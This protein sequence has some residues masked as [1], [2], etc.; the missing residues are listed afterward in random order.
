MSDWGGTNSVV[1]SIEA[2][3]DIQMP[4]SD[5]YR[6]EKTLQAI[7][8]G[9]LSKEAVEKAAANILYLVERTKGNDLS[10]EPAER[11]D[12]REETR[13]LIRNLGAE[14]LTL[15]KNEGNV[16]PIKPS[17]TKIAVIGS[18][19]NRAIAGGGGSAS[20]NPYY[21]TLPLDSIKAVPGKEVIYALGCHTYKWLPLAADYC[22]TASGEQG[23]MLEFFGGDQFEGTPKVI[24]QRSNTDLFLWDSAPLEVVGG[25]WSVRA[26]TRITPV[27]SGRHTISF[28]TVGPGRLL[29]D[30]EVKVDLWNW[31]EQGEAMFDNS[32]DI[33]VEIQMEAGKEIELVAET[34]NE[35]RPMWKQKPGV[36]HKYGGVRI[37]YKEED[38]QDL[39]QEAISAAKASDVAIVIVGLDAEWESEGYDRRTMDLPKDGSQDR[40]I[41]EVLKANPRTIVVNQSGSP[42]TMP[43][44]DTV[45]A[46]IQGWYQGQEAG[47]A[48]ADV[49]FGLKNPSGKLPVSQDSTICFWGKQLTISLDHFPQKARGQPDIP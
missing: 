11:E 22:T 26:K 9:K 28:S 33:L 43:W 6:G 49:L 29:V 47:N 24:Q 39:L 34:T 18:N 41:A 44:A 35:I 14:G 17:E 8:D 5:E 7:K 36:T 16:L 3:C 37:G 46:I 42:V 15:L 12:D 31:T 13:K 27:T 4:V 1:E 45:P 38:G 10:E 25:P 23:V 48:L 30:G 20:L 2:G 19:A 40:L 21:N 32:K